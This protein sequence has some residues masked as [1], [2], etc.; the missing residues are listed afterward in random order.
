MKRWILALV[1]ALALVGSARVAG[2]QDLK[3][4]FK[5]R[6]WLQGMVLTEH[7]ADDDRAKN[8]A[9]PHGLAYGDLRADL[10][11]RLPKGFEL[12]LDGRIRLT[13]EL[14][15]DLRVRG[16]G[17]FTARGYLGGREYDLRQ[18]YIMRRGKRVSFA[19]G[20]MYVFEA[21]ALK[22]DGGRLWIHAQKHW[23][24]SLHAGG[25]PNPYSRSVTTDYMGA[26][27]F[28][29]PSIVGGAATA[30]TYDKIWGS[31]GV[32]AAY[33][34]GNNDGSPIDPAAPAAAVAGTEGVRAYV[35]WTNMVRFIHWLDLYHD[36]VLDVA[37]AAGV[38]LTRLNA[39]ATARA[40]QHFTIRAGYHHLAPIAVEMFLLNL[41]ADRQLVLGAPSIQ[42]NLTVMRTAR[43][44]A[45][46]YADAH[47]GLVNIFAEGRLRIRSTTNPGDYPVFFYDAQTPVAPPLA[48][49]LTAG[50]RDRGTL[51][52]LRL[53]LWYTY[54][55]DYRSDNHILGAEL[56][57]SF[58]DERLTFD[59]TFLYGRTRDARDPAV[60][61]MGI[62]CGPG[63]APAAPAA[64]SILLQ[65][66]GARDGHSYETA[67][68]L[69]GNPWKHWFGLLDYRLVVNQNEGRPEL[70]THILLLR[71]EARY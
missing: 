43:D 39:F 47:W 71:V 35:T 16:G 48:L 14:S 33:L 56:G 57:R 12:K 13:D 2:A 46:L 40:G 53:G 44:Q 67:L 22:L 62:P 8:D 60:M 19:V 27:G 18:A 4:K 55:S 28:Y 63:L 11:A 41:L 59:L 61:A 51:R 9:A 54:L 69:T 24:V 70:F 42:N 7:Q 25:Y 36:L 1:G 52:G 34:G 68:T 30:Y 21:D 65:C 64:Q 15:R 6:V 38:Q 29:G 58:L 49:D 37:G 17:G 26:A 10:L 66:Y 3:D 20:R 45:N 32:T 50:I 31:F 23:D 5:I